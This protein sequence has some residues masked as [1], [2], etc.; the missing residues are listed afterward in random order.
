MKFKTSTPYFK[1]KKK[2][3]YNPTRSTIILIG[4]FNARVGIDFAE[5][6]PDVG[7]YSFGETNE[8]GF[9]LLQFCTV[10]KLILTNTI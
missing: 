6:I 5:S 4:D 3:R 7:K 1:K 10:N 2:N 9:R 8:R